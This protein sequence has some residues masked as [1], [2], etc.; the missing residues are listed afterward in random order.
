MNYN[1]CDDSLQFIQSVIPNKVRDLLKLR[2][3]LALFGMTDVLRRIKQSLSVLSISFLLLFSNLA[4]PFSAYT[5]EEL[6][7]LEQEFVQ[8]INHSDAVLRDPIAHDYINHVGKRLA[9]FSQLNPPDFFIVKSN[10]INAFAGPGGHIG[11][12]TQLI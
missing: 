9:E 2:R 7:Q 3:C 10:E 8:E 1:K 11:V 5:N 4:Q 6:D 12:N